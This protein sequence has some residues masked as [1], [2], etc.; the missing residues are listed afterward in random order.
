MRAGTLV[1]SEG[2]CQYACCLWKSHLAAWGLGLPWRTLHL[3]SWAKGQNVAILGERPHKVM[4]QVFSLFPLRNRAH[5]FSWVADNFQIIFLFLLYCETLFQAFLDILL[6][7]IFMTQSTCIK[8]E[9]F[10]CSAHFHFTLH[11]NQIE[12]FSGINSVDNVT[13]ESFIS[14]KDCTFSILP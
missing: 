12:H 1:D 13:L 6:H 4:L 2:Q 7:T 10:I 3:F 9:M 5:A 8:R 14:M 11:L